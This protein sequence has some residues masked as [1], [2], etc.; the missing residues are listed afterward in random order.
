MNKKLKIV[1]MVS[2]AINLIMLGFFIGNA[3][4]RHLHPEYVYEKEQ[5]RVEKGPLMR[6]LSHLPAEQKDQAKKELKQLREK[7]K[8][9]RQTM[10]QLREELKELVSVEPFQQDQF[11][12]KTQ[13]IRQLKNQLERRHTRYIAKILAQLPEE[14][15]V[16]AMRYFFKRHHKKRQD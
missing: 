5:K 12:D 3:G 8:E 16:K 9:T 2:L 13:Q 1:L 11:M 6:V 4:K 10:R 7:N 15:R 14:K